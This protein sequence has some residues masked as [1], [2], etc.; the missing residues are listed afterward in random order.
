MGAAEKLDETELTAISAKW[1]HHS[2]VTRVIG[3]TYD[4]IAK[5]RQR[6]VWLEGKQWR[7]NPL[8]KVVYNL[9]AIDDWNEG[10]L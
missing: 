8:G 7:Y 4:Q 3:Y 10:V 1:V 5:Y 2:I 9:K 6:G